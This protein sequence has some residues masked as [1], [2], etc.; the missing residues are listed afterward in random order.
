[1]IHNKHKID[2]SDYYS[3][4]GGY[5][6]LFKVSNEPLLGFKEFICKSRADYAR[7]IQLK[8]SKYNLAPKV[9][10]KLCKMGY[11]PVFANQ[12]SGWGYV[13]ELAEPTN[14]NM[15]PWKIQKL[16]DDI[17]DRTKLKFWDCH[18]ANVGY[19]I[20]QGK[21]KLVC[22]DTG[23]ETWDGYANYFGNSDPGPKCSYCLRYQCKCLEE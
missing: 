7:K 23:K 17:F 20:R 6:T 2:L 8:L 1:M 15:Q 16:V 14:P 13:T 10:S 4:N 12:I 5:C 18:T 22:I 19:I 3:E 21:K 9:F 11:E